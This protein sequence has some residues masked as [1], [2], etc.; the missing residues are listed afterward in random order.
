MTRPRVSPRGLC[1]DSRL[2]PNQALMMCGLRFTKPS[3]GGLA[4]LRLRSSRT[5]SPSS[6]GLSSLGAIAPLR[7][8]YLSSTIYPVGLPSFKDID[9]RCAAL[10]APS[11]ST[12]P[13]PEHGVTSRRQSVATEP[14]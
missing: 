7:T 10:P 11:Y 1:T 2:S 8:D 3:Y 5:M 13:W 9:G 6:D 14:P 4:L 12:G